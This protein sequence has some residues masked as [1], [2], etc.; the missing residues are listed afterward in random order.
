MPLH[1]QN[2]EAERLAETLAKI[3]GQSVPDA[4]IQA[5]QAQIAR[6]EAQK[7]QVETM[8]A[9]AMAIGHRCANLPVLDPRSDDDLLGYGPNGL[10]S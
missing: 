4:V 3:T 2:A 8:V 7:A 1:I 6:E 5:L 9:E 10:P